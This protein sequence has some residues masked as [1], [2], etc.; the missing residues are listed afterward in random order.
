MKLFFF[1]T[2]LVEN[3]FWLVKSKL[4][5]AIRLAR[6]KL[7]SS[8]VLYQAVETVFCGFH[9]NI[10]FAYLHIFFLMNSLSFVKPAD[11]NGK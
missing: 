9:S 2:R 7:V 1:F 3:C 8:P 4:S 6:K 5:L 11:I 10:H